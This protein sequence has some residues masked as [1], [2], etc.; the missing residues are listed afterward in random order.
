MSF[1][2]DIGEKTLKLLSNKKV[3]IVVVFDLI[4][5]AGFLL[6]KPMPPVDNSIDL[7]NFKNYHKEPENV[8]GI[9]IKI[10][11]L[12]PDFVRIIPV[13]I[14]NVSHP[15]YDNWDSLTF[16]MGYMFEG[17]KPYDISVSPNVKDYLERMKKVEDKGRLFDSYRATVYPEKL[18]ARSDF[19][20]Y[21]VSFEADQTPYL[22][23]VTGGVRLISVGRDPFS[24]PYT[25]LDVI[26]IPEGSE[27]LRV[28]DFAPYKYQKIDGWQLFY[29]DT[30]NIDKHE[31]IHIMFNQTSDTAASIKVENLFPEFSFNYS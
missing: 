6:V 10:W 3:V 11:E 16:S 1:I 21:Y 28:Y 2:D 24:G 31:S 14:F 23:G 15:L 30:T 17:E 20:T 4:L 12:H 26:A 5:I 18:V 22:H 8:L 19:V 27:I 25:Q 13:R 9:Y 29:Y 7:E